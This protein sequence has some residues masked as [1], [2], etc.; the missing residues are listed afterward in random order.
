MKALSLGLIG[1]ALAASATWAFPKVG[2]PVAAIV[3]PVWNDPAR[4]DAAHEVDQIVARLRL[5][6]GMT[7]ADIGAGDGYDTLRLARALG[8]RGTVIAEDVTPAYLASLRAAVAARR[9][10]NVRVVLGEAG[11]PKLAPRSIDAA[12]MVHMYHEVAEPYALLARLA[13]AFRPGGRL[14][15]E[16][17]D[18]PTR[19]HGT[20]PHILTCELAAAGYHLLSLAPLQGGLGYFAV[21]APPPDPRS[22]SAQVATACR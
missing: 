16:E 17:L 3:S 10:A 4:R 9:L 5:R 2:R 8:P 18:R 1:M 22:P 7:V 6:P 21:F 12:I 15:V 14:G 19:N 11:N 13:P 20:P